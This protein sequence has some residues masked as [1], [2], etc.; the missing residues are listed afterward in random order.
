MSFLDETGLSYFWSKIKQRFLLISGGTL[1]GGLTATSLT[2]TGATKT[3]SLSINGVSVNDFV[4]AQGMS[5]SIFYRKWNSGRFECHG[6]F[7]AT[8]ANANVLQVVITLPATLT[9]TT[10]VLSSLNDAGGNSSPAL[11]WNTKVTFANNSQILVTVHGPSGD[12]GAQS[13]IVGSFSVY[14]RWK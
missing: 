4:T 14:G 3:K 13:A 10:A 7:R 2:S 11:G 1:T 8:Y 6:P 5:G 12:F 9:A